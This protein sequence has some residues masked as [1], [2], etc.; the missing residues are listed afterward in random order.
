MQTRSPQRSRRR[1][2]YALLLVIALTGAALILA[3]GVFQY[4]S[5]TAGLNNRHVEHQRAVAAA[6]AAT[7][8]VV[9]SVVSDFREL[10]EGYILGHLDGYRNMVPTAAEHPAAGDFLFQNLAS[11]ND[12]LEVTYLPGSGFAISSG[13]YAGLRGTRSQLRVV[14]NAR[15][16]YA[17]AGP[18]GAVYQDVELLRIPIFQFAVFYNIIMEIDNG[19]NT[20]TITGPVHCNTNAYFDPYNTLTFNSDVT[21]SGTIAEYK[22]AGHPM[23]SPGSGAIIYNGAHDSG[24]STLNLPIGTNTSPA[25]VHAVIEIPPV[26]EDPYSSIGQQRYYNKA[27][28][29]ILVKDTNIVATSG[30]KNSFLTQI[31]GSQITNFLSTNQTFYNK[32]E[33]KTIKATEIDIAKLIQWNAT[34]TYLRPWL[35][36]QDIRVLFVDDQRTQSSS[37]QPGV[38]LINGQTLLPQG[39]TVATP[40]PL[41]TVS[42]YNAPAAHLGTTNTSATL[43][44]SLIADAVTVLSSAWNDGNASSS[45]SS[46]VAGNT[47]VNAAILTG[48]VPS[49]S[50]SY[51]GGVQN[52][53]RLL[54]EWNGRTLTYNGS[55]VAMFYSQ[56]ATNIWRGIGS[57]YDIYN[58]PVRN[59]ALDQNFLVESKLPPATPSV[60]VLVRGKWRAPAPYTTN[61]LA[62]F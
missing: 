31:P 30:L 17:S 57:S 55:M 44:A 53:P 21:A 23:S 9:S 51:S 43:P 33:Q 50:A 7:E 54:E 28:L 46:R 5:T 61:V 56:V 3:T 48:Q 58:A 62:G 52:F 29:I 32:R 60:T 19:P 12:R 6:E 25:A 49:S 34:N 15:A 35:P 8:K 24:V 2:G 47:T 59:W 18:V 1:E 16:R 39:L 41:Y 22:L 27:D 10:G 20:F 42:H 11:D 26:L 4:A 40:K 37:T 36:G 38:R 45:L 14:A 13:Q